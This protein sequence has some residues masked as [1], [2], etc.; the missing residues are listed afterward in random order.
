MLQKQ[1]RYHTCR[2]LQEV[3]VMSALSHEDEQM[4][5]RCEKTKHVMFWQKNDLLYSAPWR[6]NS[7]LD[8]N[9]HN[10]GKA[11]WLLFIKLTVKAS[12]LPLETPNHSDTICK[13]ILQ[14]PQQTVAYTYVHAHMHTHMHTHSLLLILTAVCGAHLQHNSAVHTSTSTA[15]PQRDANVQL[16]FIAL[17]QSY[18]EQGHVWSQ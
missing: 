8:N 10:G 2:F 15:N 9:L 11:V 6:G 7:T 1:I 18:T 5:N 16:I 12:C 4:W 14:K 3:S 13:L 17:K